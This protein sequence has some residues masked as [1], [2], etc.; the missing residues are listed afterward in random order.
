[1][2]LFTKIGSKAVNVNR[3]GILVPRT[4]LCTTLVFGSVDILIQ[5]GFAFF[6][7]VIV[8]DLYLPTGVV[9]STVPPTIT[10]FHTTLFGRNHC[11]A[12]TQ[13]LGVV[14]GWSHN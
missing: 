8:S 13:Q 7:S 4:R 9:R 10:A 6:P 12:T 2:T 14:D 1:M 11:A 3:I 5:V